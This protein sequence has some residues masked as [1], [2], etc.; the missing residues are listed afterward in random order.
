VAADAVATVEE[1]FVDAWIAVVAKPQIDL[2]DLGQE[3]LVLDRACGGISVLPPAPVVV[4]GPGNSEHLTHQ[5]DVDL[6]VI[7]LLRT[8]VGIDVY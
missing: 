7:G 2:S 5:L 3:Q 1:L 4:A 6:G 8:D